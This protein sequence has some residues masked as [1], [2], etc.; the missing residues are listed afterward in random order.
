[1]KN[2]IIGF[3]DSGQRLD[4]FLTKALPKLP[5]NLMYKYIRKKRIKVNN[6]RCDI[7]QFLNVGDVVELYVND[8]FF[9]TSNRPVEFLLSDV[10][11]D[12]VYEDKNILIVN[13]NVGVLSHSSNISDSDTLVNRIKR[14]LYSKGEYDL[15]ELSF[16]PAL[17]NRLDRNTSG[18]VICAKNFMALKLI[19]EK[20][21]S[22]Q[23][24]KHY[25]CLVYGLFS[26]K[27]GV[28]TGYLLKN[29]IENKVY[30]SEKKLENSKKIITK[31]NVLDEQNNI[32][33]LEVELITGR[34]HQI[35]AHFNYIGHPLVGDK[36]YFDSNIVPDIR[37]DKQALFSSKIKFDFNS[38][39]GELKYLKGRDIS[40]NRAWF[41]DI[42][43]KKE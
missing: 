35:R 28:L 25:L 18:L 41:I 32:S 37:F 43:Y 17:C 39:S 13:K 6:K 21:R 36:K 33:L 1:M 7:S 34:T 24:S 20:I 16:S 19:N 12:I 40:S 26:N 30:I 9:T 2:F 27:Q 11:L 8:E 29:R 10:N 4:K 14:Y 3:N 38:D 15:E 31:Y 5:K 23:I 42:F 22:R